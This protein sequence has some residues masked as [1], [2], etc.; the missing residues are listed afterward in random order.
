MT[1]HILIVKVQCTIARISQYA[2]LEVSNAWKE[3]VGG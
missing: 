2:S 3:Y 1:P